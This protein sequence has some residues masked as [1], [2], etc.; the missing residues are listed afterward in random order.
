MKIIHHIRSPDGML[1][2]IGAVLT[3][4]N[5]VVTARIKQHKERKEIEN[6]L[7]FEKL[8]QLLKKK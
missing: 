5:C 8:K 2:A 4:T 6:N 1:T 3:I 7:P